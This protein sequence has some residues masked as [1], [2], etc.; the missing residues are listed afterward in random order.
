MSNYR[1]ISNIRHT[2]F[3]NL[4]DSH[5]VLKS[6]LPNPLKPGVKLRMKM[7]LEQRR[8]AMLQ[9]HLSDRQFNCLRYVFEENAASV[10]HS[11]VPYILLYF[12]ELTK[13]NVDVITIPNK[14]NVIVHE[15]KTKVDLTK[16][17][18]NQNF[19]FDYAFDD[20]CDNEMVYR[21]VT[22]CFS[23]I[24]AVIHCA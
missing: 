23:Q 4:N 3:Q 9:L 17:L 24:G 16:Y 19:R 20:M 12:P 13:Q 10:V 14:E 15:P 6:S 18:E 21:W 2:K 22:S 7:Q 8:Q 1:K 5:L 11:K